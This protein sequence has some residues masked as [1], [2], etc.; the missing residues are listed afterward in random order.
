MGV[1]LKFDAGAIRIL[2]KTICMLMFSSLKQY[3]S[4]IINKRKL[5]KTNKDMIHM[6]IQSA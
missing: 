1:S 6:Y 3:K 2:P 5:N 4:S